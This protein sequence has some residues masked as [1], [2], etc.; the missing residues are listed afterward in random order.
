MTEA[1]R[2]RGRSKYKTSIKKIKDSSELR[3]Y[4]CGKSLTKKECTIDHLTPL[5][6]GGETIPR[7]LRV[8]CL[9][10]NREKAS[11]T[12]EEYRHVKGLPEPP[13]VLHNPKK[14]KQK[15]KKLPKKQSA[16]KTPTLADDIKASYAF[17]QNPIRRRKAQGA[18]KW[19][20]DNLEKEKRYKEQYE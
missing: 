3:C 17:F 9:D 16:K 10:C 6:R 11:L 5:S 12:E 20:R 19:Q 2:V 8:C 18:L 15:T 4:Y 13:L 1:Q 14:S 7:N